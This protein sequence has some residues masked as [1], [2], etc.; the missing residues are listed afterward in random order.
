MIA[1]LAMQ[2]AL[3]AYHRAGAN[4]LSEQDR[5]LATL[6]YF[7]SEVENNGFAHFYR[8]P[9]GELAA[10]A[11]AAFRAIGAPDFAAIAERANA[12]FGSA[13]VPAGQAERAQAVARLGPAAR[14]VFDV[15]ED[16][17]TASELD[18]DPL[19]E[20]YV[21]ADGRDGTERR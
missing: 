15:L 14:A 17:Y 6:W 10:F 16:E 7:E 9:A 1:D 8:S 21:A 5:T 12:V 4:R 19:V 13:G 2:R 11:P 20:A 3:D 18:L